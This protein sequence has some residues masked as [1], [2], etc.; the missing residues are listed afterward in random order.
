MPERTPLRG[1]V[2]QLGEGL[3]RVAELT[4]IAAAACLLGAALLAWLLGRDYGP[5][6]VL[7]CA[8]VGVGMIF[9]GSWQNMPMGPLA[10]RRRRAAEERHREEERDPAM[11]ARREVE[12]R[13]PTPVVSEGGILTAAGLLLVVVGFLADVLVDRA[14]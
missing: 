13:R 1:A 14:G 10:R 9:G 11:R 12:A 2:R 3:L 8:L 5:T 7:V 4:A 6:A